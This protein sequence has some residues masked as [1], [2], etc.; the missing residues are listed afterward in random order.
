MCTEPTSLGVLMAKADKYATADSA[1][2]IKVT[3]SDKV[4]P[5]PATPKPTGDNRGGQNNYKRKADQMHPRSNSKMV[6][7]VE[8]EAS[9]SQAG[10]PRKRPNRRNPN[11]L[12]RHAACRLSQGDGMPTPPG[13]RAV[14]V[15]RLPITL[16]LRHRRLEMTVITQTTILIKTEHSSS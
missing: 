15:H 12:P 9:D 11:W 13:A 5:T 10:P 1:M 3:A 2:R 6:A 16:R 8:G 4:V 14:P 7:N